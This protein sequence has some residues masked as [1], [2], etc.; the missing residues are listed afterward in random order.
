MA[1]LPTR[2]L[3][4]SAWSC[5][6]ERVPADSALDLI[7]DRPNRWNA[8]G[9]PTIYLS[10]DAAL[11]L[12]EAGRHPDD[13]EGRSRLIEIDLRMRAA[14]DL[15]EEDVRTA[16]QLPDPLDWIFDRELTREIARS[17]RQ[18]GMCDGLVV[19]SAGALDQ[20]AR[21]NAVVFAEDRARLADLIGRI[22]PAGEIDL[23]PPRTRARRSSGASRACRSPARR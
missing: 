14:V 6:A 17:L 23:S 11:A 5:R 19:P 3:R 9:E 4:A 20:Q 22:R 1:T 12:L 21:W 7:S 18:S 10:S 15:R 13:L 16:L 2:P 8:E